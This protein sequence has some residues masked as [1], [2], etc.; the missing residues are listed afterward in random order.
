MKICQTCGKELLPTNE[1][2]CSKACYN[3]ARK[4]IRFCEKCGKQIQR[5]GT[6][7]FCSKK[8]WYEWHQRE[9]HGQYERVEIKCQRCGKVVLKT[10]SRASKCEV[11]YCSRECARQE[12]GRK[13]SGPR[14]K[15]WRGGSA[16]GRGASWRWTRIEVLERQNHKCAHC[17]ITD[18]EHKERYGKSLH[19]H[20]KEPY[21]LTLNSNELVALCIPCHARAESVI[22]ASLTPKQLSVIKRNTANAANNGLGETT[23]YDYD[24]CPSCGSLK[25]KRAKLCRT[26]HNIAKTKLSRTCP[27]CGGSKG[28]YARRCRKCYFDRGKGKPRPGTCI[29]CSKQLKTPG[30]KRCRPCNARVY[31][32]LSKGPRKYYNHKS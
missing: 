31:G 14:N 28:P 27:L 21:R 4:K 20:H 7:R 12:H 1:R 13:I 26:C 25:S 8:C 16:P 17:G 3:T 5:K 6:S 29:D 22:R 32:K 11:N 18:N 10:P 15:Y 2:Y 24:K 9:N 23:Y 19:I 30:A